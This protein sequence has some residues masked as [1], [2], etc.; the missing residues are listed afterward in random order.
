MPNKTSVACIGQQEIPIADQKNT[1]IG[2]TIPYLNITYN[3]GIIPPSD[4]M[5][6]SYS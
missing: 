1:R 5:N 2:K 6:N 3:F 4:N